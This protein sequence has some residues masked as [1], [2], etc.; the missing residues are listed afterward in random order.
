MVYP[1]EVT[2]SAAAK[3]P[4]PDDE[5][6]DD[7]ARE[8]AALTAIGP[9]PNIIRLIGWASTEDVEDEEDCESP[10]DDVLLMELAAG[11][12]ADKLECASLPH[13][14]EFLHMLLC[15]KADLC[16]Q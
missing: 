13:R 1:A 4:R 3:E 2:Y 12:L 7:L 11:S 6:R 14:L 15:L 16:E 5:C 10:P 9:H 8:A